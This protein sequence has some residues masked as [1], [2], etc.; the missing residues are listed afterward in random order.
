MLGK[1]TKAKRYGLCALVCR[2]VKKLKKTEKKRRASCIE[3]KPKWKKASTRHERK[4]K[5]IKYRFVIAPKNTRRKRWK[6]REKEIEK[7]RRCFDSDWTCSACCC[8][9]N[10]ALNKNEVK[11]MG[12]KR[13]KEE[14]NCIK[15]VVE[16]THT[17]EPCSFAGCCCCFFLFRI[18]VLRC[19]LWCTSSMSAAQQQQIGNKKINRPRNRYENTSNSIN[20]RRKNRFCSAI[21]WK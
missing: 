2:R 8:A 13:M 14:M 11:Y 9:I 21:V 10:P 7:R 6:Y 20:R 3:N 19:S 12:T 5:V 18:F 16:R 1:Q 4:I 15:E 17:H